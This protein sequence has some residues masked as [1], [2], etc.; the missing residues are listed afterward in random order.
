MSLLLHLSDLHL[1]NT[2]KSDGVGDYSKSEAV[3][4]TDRVTRAG[5]LRSTLRALDDYL[6]QNNEIL[7][8][9]VVTGDI[10]TQARPSGLAEL[11]ALLGALGDSLPP[12]SKVVVLPGN[13]DVVW[14]TTPAS[15]ERY[16]PFVAH[17]RSQGFV[18]PLLDGID[19][20]DG[21]AKPG[22]SALLVG[23]DFVVV[24]VNSANWCGVQE[25]LPP[26]VEACLSELV[27]DG[28]MEA[29]I[30][31]EIR[32]LQLYDMARISPQQMSALAEAVSVVTADGHSRVLIAAV[33]HQLAP[34]RDEEEIKPYESLVNAA[35]FLGFLGDA[36]FDI[37]LH[38]HKHADHVQSLW[39]PDGASVR[40][41]AVASC[42]TV[43]GQVGTGNE[44][45]KLVRIHSDLPTIRSVEVSSIPAVGAGRS[46][47][48]NV[49]TVHRTSTG[50]ARA[51]TAVTVVGGATAAAVHERLMEIARSPDR[52]RHDLICVIDEGSTAASPPPTYPW[53][54]DAPETLGEWFAETVGWWQDP[55]RHE[56]K[57]FTHGQRLRSWS[58]S[59]GQPIDQL[60]AVAEA[61]R[62]DPTTS[63]G[64]AALID[65]SIDRA[66][67]SSINFPSFSLLHAW[68]SGGRL[69]CSAFFR[70]QEMKYWWA[71]NA[72]E[73]AAVQASLIQELRANQPDLL[74]GA[75][76]TH[77]SEAVFSDRLPRVN[78]PRLDRKFWQ[79]AESVRVL[80]VAVADVA[81][82]HRAADLEL[83][84]G[85]LEEAAPAADEPPA[86]G[87]P[88][89]DPGLTAL[90]AALEALGT[91]YPDSPAHDAADL[92]R[93]IR[94]ANRHYLRTRGGDSA[95]Y[96]EWR[97]TVQR[98]LARLRDLLR[99]QTAADEAP[100]SA[101]D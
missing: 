23:A 3:S 65:P 12:S 89:A 72:A 16:Q 11:P 19:Y 59:T 13:H 37:V 49:R 32:R 6:R 41:I 57:P 56:E 46:L 98:K 84:L 52:P 69:H 31:A 90:V 44:V 2:G 22:A 74:P 50:H 47:R 54:P 58:G 81:A 97:N 100:T 94:D 28:K 5:L 85:L 76:R 61:L 36:G 29:E 30:A 86:D 1:G 60:K 70:K 73:I 10:T 96:H 95:V 63:R 42:G 101:S 24:A 77:A 18:T 8:A 43:G 68:I 40:P 87:A 7:D 93:D 27:A 92:L 20:E 88:A 53:P 26:K 17:V 55:T 4:A 34:V 35:A 21:A 62:S 25:S 66:G 82:P 79:D 64:V 48:D 38:G 67:D 14:A 75:I 15:V 91:R 99:P 33:H 71:V 80:A 51:T 39:V 45:A 83:L 9:V 78:V